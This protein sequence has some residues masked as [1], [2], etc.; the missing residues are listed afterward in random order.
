MSGAELHAHGDLAVEI[1]APAVAARPSSS[2]A[3][4]NSESCFVSLF[5]EPFAWTVNEKRP[6]W[7]G[8]PEMTPFGLSVR[9]GRQ[10]AAGERPRADGR[11]S[12]AVSAGAV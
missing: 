2:G 6:L 10:R 4:T 11:A 1:G 7:V 12:D 5:G 9:P 8:V 3:S